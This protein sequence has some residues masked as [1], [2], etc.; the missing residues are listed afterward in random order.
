[1]LRIAICDDDKIVCAQLEDFITQIEEEEHSVFE[2]E[3]FYTGESLLRALYEES[4]DIIFLDIELLSMT[5]IDVGLA[6]RNEKLDENTQII[7]ISSKDSYAMGLFKTRPLDF[8]IKPLDYKAV[9]HVTLV[10]IKL[11]KQKNIYFE[12]L[13]QRHVVRIPTT[14]IL[15]FET[16]GKK[17]KI[18]TPSGDHI[19]YGKKRDVLNQISEELFLDIHYSYMVN[20]NHVIEFTYQHVVLSNHEILPISQKRRKFM[21]EWLL[22]RRES[23][24]HDG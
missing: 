18:V 21:R 11:L 24:G 8:L 13:E 12:F 5:G 20:F 3:V 23:L 10:A 4:Y 16:L 9:R 19:F 14:D 7:Y 17:V 22:K 6:I 1:M 15:Y 2:T